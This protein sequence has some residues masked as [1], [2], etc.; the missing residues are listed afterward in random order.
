MLGAWLESGLCLFFL[1]CCFH[2]WRRTSPKSEVPTGGLPTKLLHRP[3]K[4]FHLS[5]PNLLYL[6]DILSKT[7]IWG[8]G[9]ADPVS[10]E[11]R[12]TE[13]FQES[14]CLAP[15]S[16][17]EFLNCNHFFRI[18]FQWYCV[19]M[20][21]W[22]AIEELLQKN[23]DLPQE[24]DWKQSR[25][26]LGLRC[27][28]TGVLPFNLQ[29]RVTILYLV[30]RTSSSRQ[31]HLIRRLWGQKSIRLST[32]CTFYKCLFTILIWLHCSPCSL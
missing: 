17:I 14:F 31:P 7:D 22:R 1:W 29:L 15:S 5:R 23:P 3:G 8:F 26:I 11:F 16:R 20:E 32:S 4:P 30:M 10:S 12:S 25:K 19:Q 18:D 21:D 2:S 6:L 9:T 13:V 24:R 28:R 27:S